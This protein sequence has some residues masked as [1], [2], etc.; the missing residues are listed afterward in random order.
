[1]SVEE[2]LRSIVTY[3]E[4]SHLL[5]GEKQHLYATFSA[6]LRSV[7]WPILVSHMPEEKLSMLSNKASQVTI[8]EYYGLI[9]VSLTDMTVLTE[10]EDLMLTMLDG[11]E[12][13]LRERLVI[14]S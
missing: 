13:V 10:L 12:K 1:M 11:A 5:A 14:T 7:V 3:I 2:K 8:E 4:N 9:K 6:S